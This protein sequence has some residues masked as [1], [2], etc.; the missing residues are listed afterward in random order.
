MGK[1]YRVTVEELTP[2][3]D[4]DLMGRTVA[5]FMSPAEVLARFVPGAVAELLGAERAAVTV[6]LPQ[7]VPEQDEAPTEVGQPQTAEQKQRR[8][9]R[10]KAEIEAEKQPEQ[11]AAAVGEAGPAAEGGAGTP[12]A[13]EAQTAGSS[14]VDAAWG[15]GPSPAAAVPTGNPPTGNPPPAAGTY[16]PFA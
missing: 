10:T 14:A 15:A 11:A 13:L 1:I 6:V 12:V 2:D 4:G 16:N 3:G 8:R 9:R 5:E 7:D